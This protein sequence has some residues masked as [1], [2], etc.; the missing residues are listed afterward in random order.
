MSGNGSPKGNR[1]GNLGNFYI[2]LTTGDLYYYFGQTSGNL[3]WVSIWNSNSEFLTPSG[4]GSELTNLSTDQLVRGILPIQRGGTGVNSITGLIRGNGEAPF[5]QA[6]DGTDYLGPSMTGVISYYAGDNVPTGWLVCDGSLV[7]KNDYLRL[8]SKIGDKYQNAG[9]DVGSESTTFRL[10]NLIDKYVKGGTVAGTRGEPT[11]GPHT[12]TLTGSTDVNSHTHNRGTFDI[13]GV[14]GTSWMSKGE[15]QDPTYQFTGCFFKIPS[16]K[17]PT[18]AISGGKPVL[19]S[20][21]K[22]LYYGI[23]DKNTSN[24]DPGMGFQAALNCTGESGVTSHSHTI[25]GSTAVN[26]TDAENDVA[27]ITMIPIIKY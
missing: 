9:D 16:K 27:H 20:D 13:R 14:A 23:N 25:S 8:Y 15:W 10:P 5:S 11:V 2:D 26:T 3:D 7:N 1:D 18:W 22:A 24:N 19:E 6:V 21:S 17:K 4:D 12:H